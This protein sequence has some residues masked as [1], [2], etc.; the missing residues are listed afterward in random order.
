MMFAHGYGCDQNMWR[1]VWPAFADAYRIVLFDHVG[2][3]ASDH[4]AY[5]REKYGT[6]AGYAQDLLEICR[7]LE[8]R[9]VILVAHS[10]SAVI[11]VL[12]AAE[13]PDRFAKLVL[14]GPSPR[15]RRSGEYVHRH[16]A[17]SELVR[18][19][20]WPRGRGPP[21]REHRRPVRE[22]ADR[23]LLLAP[24]RD[25][26]QGQRDTASPDAVRAR[27][28]RG[29]EAAARPARAGGRGSITRHTTRRS[30]R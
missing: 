24:R 20:A 12:A 25:A 27:R 10:V 17:E 8:L 6:L 21:R 2:A 11:V 16:L 3:G 9:D 23:V 13:E 19:A 4:A 28:A 18:L 29:R 15:I 26:R 14:V 1:H 22:C 30:S 7:E 5:D